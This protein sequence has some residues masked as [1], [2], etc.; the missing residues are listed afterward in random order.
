[1][2]LPEE[3]A[4]DLESFSLHPALLDMATG[5][6]QQ[7]IPG[8]QQDKTF[9]VPFSYGRLLFREGPFRRNCSVTYV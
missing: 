8:F 6:A 1:M 2:V 5:G 4:S 9:F 3:F 7:L